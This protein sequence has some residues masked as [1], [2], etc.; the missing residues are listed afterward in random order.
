MINAL[1]AAFDSD[2]RLRLISRDFRLLRIIS[3]TQRNIHKIFIGTGQIKISRKKSESS[4]YR[5][6]VGYTTVTDMMLR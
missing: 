2:F 5:I 6:F 3:T 4:S 1:G